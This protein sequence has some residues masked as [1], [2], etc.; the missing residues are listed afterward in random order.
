VVNMLFLFG[1][2]PILIFS[3]LNFIQAIALTL[4]AIVL[5]PVLILIVWGGGILVYDISFNLVIPY[6]PIGTFLMIMWFNSFDGLFLITDDPL[7][8]SMTTTRKSP[9]DGESEG[10][11]GDESG[12]GGRGSDENF[13]T[14]EV[15]G[16]F[17]GDLTVRINNYEYGETV[18]ED[19]LDDRTQR[20]IYEQDPV[21]PEE[22][23]ISDIPDD[24]PDDF[25]R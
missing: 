14:E 2:T 17:D 6:I 25:H 20:V 16:A 8:S 15:E 5:N 18:D 7:A 10:D 1:V 19:R 12:G 11:G 3:P 22:I 23:N 9:D 4:R 13:E 24:D 21:E